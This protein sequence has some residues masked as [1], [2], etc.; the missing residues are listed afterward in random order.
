MWS[1]K[2]CVVIGASGGIGSAFVR[3]LLKRDSVERV[4]AGSTRADYT[5]PD[6]RVTPCQVDYRQPKTI[7]ALALAVSAESLRLDLVI[8]ATP[9]D[10]TRL[11]TIERPHMHIGYRLESSDGAITDAIKRVVT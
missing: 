4:F 11:L 1:P 5:H 2:N 9:I 7:G 6:P 3:H 10:L 8:V